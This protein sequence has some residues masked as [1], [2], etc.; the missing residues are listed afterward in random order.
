MEAKDFF[1]EMVNKIWE[2]D[3]ELQSL[4]LE[5]F[6]ELYRKCPLNMLKK[7]KAFVVFSDDYLLSKTDNMAELPQ[8]DLYYGY[9]CKFN[10]RLVIP[11]WGLDNKVNG[12]V[13]YDDGSKPAEHIYIKYLY[14]NAIV[15]P[16]ERNM[17]I[18]QRDYINAIKQNYI[19]IVDGI[20]DQ[21]TL[22]ENNIP[23]V[24][25]LGSNFTD[26]HKEYFKFIKNWV[27][28]GDND[29]AGNR[30]FNYCRK[31]N[32][33]TARI[34]FIGAKDIDEKIN[35]GADGT[36]KRLLKVIDTMKIEGFHINHTL[37]YISNRELLKN[38]I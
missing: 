6:A 21:M 3:S 24:S 13:G 14:Q 31:I 28:I 10:E 32:M 17:L 22:A 33:N 1:T 12:F 18:S 30:L 4:A 15:F 9:K 37:D 5:S 20:F 7:N 23:S 38:I 26:Y 27:V 16:K 11:I 25:L 35:N 36:L 34:S 19:C 8:Y 2:E 29:D